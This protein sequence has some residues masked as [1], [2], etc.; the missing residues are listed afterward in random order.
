MLA[1]PTVPEWRVT[2]DLGNAK[3]ILA[4]ASHFAPSTDNPDYARAAISTVAKAAHATEPH[5]RER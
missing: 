1:K 4:A 2:P 5:W 3:L